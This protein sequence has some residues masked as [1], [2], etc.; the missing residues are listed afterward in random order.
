MMIALNNLANYVQRITNK[1]REEDSLLQNVN[2]AAD[3]TAQTGNELCTQE[4]IFIL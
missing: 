4:A 3:D 2:S 1:L